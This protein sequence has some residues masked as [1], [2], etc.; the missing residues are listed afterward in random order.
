MPAEIK[1]IER[2]IVEEISFDYFQVADGWTQPKFVLRSKRRPGN[3]IRK[4]R[5]RIDR[6][7]F[8]WKLRKNKVI[9]TA[10]TEKPFGGMPIR[11]QGFALLT[12]INQ[13]KE[14]AFQNLNPIRHSI[15]VALTPKMLERIT[16]SKS[17]SLRNRTGRQEMSC[18]NPFDML[19]N[20]KAKLYHWDGIRLCTLGGKLLV[21]I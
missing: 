20:G 13:V 7:V 5:R 2:E 11:M 4:K 3:V 6:K 15:F 10:R 17:R 21:T 14:M 16:S 1:T 8:V 18:K 9:H 19:K 12:N